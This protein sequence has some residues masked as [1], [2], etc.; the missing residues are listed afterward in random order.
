ML[1]FFP[2]VG[3]VGILAW[4]DAQRV[5]ERKGAGSLEGPETRSGREW[6]EEENDKEIEDERVENP[7]GEGEEPRYQA[8]RSG[9]GSPT[10]SV[11][12]WCWCSCRPLSPPSGQWGSWHGQMPS[13]RLISSGDMP[14]MN[15]MVSRLTRWP[16]RFMFAGKSRWVK[17]VGG[18]PK[19]NSQCRQR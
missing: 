11:A 12:D 13:E 2:A 19:V 10:L 3:A 18:K 5:F 6:Q 14:P 16:W 17:T 8:T 7:P 9:R 15:S 4:P 1:A